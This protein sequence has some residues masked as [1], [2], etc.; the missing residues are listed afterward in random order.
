[1]G[2]MTDEAVHFATALRQFPY[3]NIAGIYSHFSASDS[4]PTLTAHQLTIYNDL[5]SQLKYHNITPDY[6]HMSNTASVSTIEYPQQF[7]FFRIGLGIY[8]LGPDRANLQPIMTWKTRIVNIKTVPIG[9]YIGY[10]DSYQ[11]TRLTRIALLPIGYY[12]GYQFRL[13][14]K[15]SVLINDSYAPVIGRI[16]MNITIIDVT[17]ISAAIGD[18]VMILGNAKKIN[19][20]TLA[21]IAEI[22]NVR[23]II[24]GINPII[25]RMIT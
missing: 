6:I 20:H 18:E 11:T 3:I 16:A 12:D 21:T 19:P 22:K 24:T 2:I 8:G 4:N 14:N 15:T 13:S 9:S 25:K 5:L 7:N 17:D 10:A 1:M 23:E